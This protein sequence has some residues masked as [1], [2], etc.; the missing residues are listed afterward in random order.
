L[1]HEPHLLQERGCNLGQQS[2]KT[3]L[4]VCV[5]RD[6]R[7]VVQ[8]EDVKLSAVRKIDMVCQRCD[9]RR[10]I[11]IYSKW[12]KRELTIAI[13]TGQQLKFTEIET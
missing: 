1:K 7:I 3:V 11:R 9:L 6:A 5:E 13:C 4:K 2:E 10:E 12:E 8:A